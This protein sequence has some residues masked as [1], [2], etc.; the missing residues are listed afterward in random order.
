MAAFATLPAVRCM[1]EAGRYSTTKYTMLPS[2]GKLKR[3]MSQYICL[4][5]RMACTAKYSA[6]R[7]C[8]PSPTNGIG[9][10]CVLCV[11]V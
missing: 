10:P 5:W 2:S 11:V 1:R 9:A 3:M 7:M 6:M 4:P 8:S